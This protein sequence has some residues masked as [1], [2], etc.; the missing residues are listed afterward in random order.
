MN[1]PFPRNVLNRPKGPGPLAMKGG[2]ASRRPQGAGRRKAAHH[3]QVAA[4]R[5][6]RKCRDESRLRRSENHLV[7]RRLRVTPLARMARQGGQRRATG[8]GH[9]SRR[10]RRRAAIWVLEG[11]EHQA[12]T[13]GHDQNPTCQ[14]LPCRLRTTATHLRRVL[15]QPLQCLYS[16]QMHRLLLIP[17]TTYYSQ[18]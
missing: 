10:R 11:Q 15:V 17:T 1:G 14:D 7:V 5:I 13:H 4:G 2:L 8:T 3:R 9:Q 16:T 6:V 12:L 18:A